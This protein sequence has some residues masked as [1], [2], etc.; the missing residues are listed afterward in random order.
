M[1]KRRRKLMESDERL[2]Q[3]EGTGRE[4]AAAQED[5][6]VCF[7]T[8][9]VQEAREGQQKRL[10]AREARGEELREQEK[11]KGSEEDDKEWVPVVP[12]MEAGNS[13]LQTTYPSDVVEKIVMD[14]LEERRTGRGSGGPV[15]GEGGRGEHEGKRGFG[16][17]GQHGSKGA[18]QNTLKVRDEEEEVRGEDECREAKFQTDL[19]Q[20]EEGRR[21]QEER[22]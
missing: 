20:L 10:R 7:T 21:A 12:N 14:E 11:K 2:N 1:N 5:R 3:G 17:Q 16:G 13:Y 18:L 9:E 6:R 19:R 8:E 22:S 15:R 4:P